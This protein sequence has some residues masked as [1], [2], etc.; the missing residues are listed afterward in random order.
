MIKSLFQNNTSTNGTISWFNLT[1]VTKEIVTET[2]PFTP[3]I[4]R[5]WKKKNLI[6][7]KKCNRHHTIL[8]IDIIYNSNKYG[9]A[10]HNQNTLGMILERKINLMSIKSLLQFSS[11]NRSNY[12]LRYDFWYTQKL[13]KNNMTWNYGNLII[14]C[15]MN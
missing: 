11:L 1:S 10:S 2:K 12:R 14:D 4:L 7:K 13:K 3:F 9:P 5:L 6:Y 8:T 15:F